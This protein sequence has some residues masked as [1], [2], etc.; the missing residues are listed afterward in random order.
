MKSV[1]SLINFMSFI[2]TEHIERTLVGQLNA[3]YNIDHD[4]YLLDSSLDLNLFLHPMNP[5]TV[6]TPQSIV[7][8]EKIGGNMN[9]TNFSRNFQAKNEFL[10][11][12]SNKTTYN[13]NIDLLK[14]VK[15]IQRSR[16]NIKIGFF[17]QDFVIDHLLQ[18]FE[19]SYKNRIIN[20]F[21]S[22]CVDAEAKTSS[23]RTLNIF[24]YNPFG[25]FRVIN[26]TDRS[27]EDFFLSQRSNL[28]QYSL[29][30]SEKIVFRRSTRLWSA[31]C[32]IMN[33]S[34]EIFIKPNVS[35]PAASI[36]TF[37]L[38]GKLYFLSN[39]KPNFLYPVEMPT[40][41]ILVPQ[42]IPYSEF[43]N[44]LQNIFSNTF[45]VYASSAIIAVI[46]LLCAIRYR[47]H[48]TIQFFGCAADVLN[49]LTND[50][51]GVQYQRLNR[52]EGCVIVPLTFVG[53]IIMNGLISQLQSHISQPFLQ[54][55]IKTIEDIYW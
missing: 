6:W 9:G 55:Q 25:I 7:T 26:V 24:T 29:K 17:F 48:K 15:A 13:S 39:F 12:A 53:L 11:V 37:D 16:L 49:L 22:I 35:H 18:L 30:F 20:I 33:C 8:F 28:Q 47:K 50:N 42:A 1:V 3:H 44:Y 40:M 51:S 27:F 19:W 32:D 45:Y 5:Q 43:T 14:R 21:V 34:A 31:V 4:L 2:Y 10:I 54:H 41:A 36:R 52:I 38:H 23:E 46:L